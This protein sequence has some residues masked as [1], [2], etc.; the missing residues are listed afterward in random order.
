MKHT[1]SSKAEND[2]VGDEQINWFAL[3]GASGAEMR[4]IDVGRDTEACECQ[5][6]LMMDWIAMMSAASMLCI[7]QLLPST[8]WRH[9]I[10]LLQ[11]IK[12]WMSEWK[13]KQWLDKVLQVQDCRGRNECWKMLVLLEKGCVKWYAVWFGGSRNGLLFQIIL[14][15]TTHRSFLVNRSSFV[16]ADHEVS[17]HSNGMDVNVIVFLGRAQSS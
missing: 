11:C 14:L 6:D 12:V 3:G 2:Y 13:V 7:Q 10:F 16:I 5:A 8:L 4:V 17:G 1:S 15:H 9:S